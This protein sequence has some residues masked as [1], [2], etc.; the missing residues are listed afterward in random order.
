MVSIIIP[1]Y[2]EERHLPDLLR[3]IRAQAFDDY[4][5][6]VADNHS[7][8]TTR[9]IAAEHG[10]QV[11]DGGLV[12]R[13]RNN[14]AAAAKGDVLIFFDADVV[15][16][17][18]WFLHST[19]TE[20]RERKLGAATCKITPLSDK[21]VDKVFHELYNQFMAI[22]ASF[23][24]HA[25]G[26]CIFARR[27]VHEQL[28]GFDETITLGEDTD[29]VDRAGKADTF[30]VLKSARIPVSVRRFERDGRLNIAVKYLLTEFHMRTIG[31][32][33]SDAIGYTFGHDKEAAE[34]W[35]RTHKTKQ[36]KS[37]KHTDV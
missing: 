24:P 25:P 6:I 16:P 17:D 7:K 27:D 15:L 5:I 12:A 33:R 4:E 20:F 14:G 18:P 11:V 10:A 26:F 22:T 3:S 28:G 9:T 19:V 30:G 1:T 34:E 13:G 35:E 23:R 36:P 37:K 29:Y 32:V 8:D 21:T 31:M 2:N